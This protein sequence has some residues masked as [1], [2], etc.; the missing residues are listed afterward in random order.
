MEH[1][2]GQIDALLEEEYEG[3]TLLLTA[4]GAGKADVVSRARVP[5]L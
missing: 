1:L 5:S 2:G 4:A 3:R